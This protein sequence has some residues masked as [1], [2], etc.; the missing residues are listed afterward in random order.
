LDAIATATVFVFSNKDH[1]ISFAAPKLEKLP[2]KIK[3]LRENSHEV[4]K[5]GKIGFS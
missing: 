4:T 2:L 1:N 3:M 5:T